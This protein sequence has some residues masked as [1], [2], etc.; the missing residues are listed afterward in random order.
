MKK[1]LALI[2]G[3]LCGTVASHAQVITSFSSDSGASTHEAAQVSQTTLD[4]ATLEVSYRMQ[5]LQIP[6]RKPKE[7]V[8]LLQCGRR[9]SK[10]YS[11]KTH[12]VDSLIR[13]TPKEQAL[14]NI[15][16]FKAGEQ[17][18]VFQ[19]HPEGKL[20]YTE[21]ISTDN[22]LYT[23]PQPE[24]AW[25]L[26]PETREIIGYTCCRATCT[27]RGRNYEAWYAE[28]I[29]LSIGP[30]KFR[31]LPGLIMAVNDDEGIISFEATGIRRAENPV[32]IAERNYL[33]TSRKKFLSTDRKFK[34]DPI[35]YMAVN[36]NIKIV[37]KN[38][39]GTPCEGAALMQQYNPMELE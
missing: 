30:W 28:E 39:D 36:S 1:Q 15:Q 25:K 31:G 16:N 2:A 26:Q 11:L 21:K 23:E 22:L 32:T 34:T 8:M 37:V 9:L 29:P 13:V 24:I 4:T 12:R 17:Y 33:K 38:A 6:D 14:A 18:T 3:L 5:W 19:N 27:F 7:D 35:G 10:F 20:T